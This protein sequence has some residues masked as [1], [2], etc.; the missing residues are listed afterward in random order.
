MRLL[1]DNAP[2]FLSPHGLLVVEIG[3]NREELEAAYPELPF[4]WLETSGGDGF[5]F[6]LTMEQLVG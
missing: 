4:T 3:H 1:I 6:M 5:V 2:Q